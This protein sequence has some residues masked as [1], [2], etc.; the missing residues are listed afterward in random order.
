MK[1]CNGCEIDHPSQ[2]QHFCLIKDRE[3][4]WIYYHDEVSEK[5]DPGMVMKTAK[6]VC[7]ALGFTLSLATDGKLASPSCLSY[8]LIHYVQ[9]TVIYFCL[10]P[11]VK[12][13]LKNN[14]NMVGFSQAETQKIHRSLVISFDLSKSDITKYWDAGDS[15]YLRERE[16]VNEF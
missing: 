13:T 15:T 6:S 3:G 10:K 12:Q 11:P 9:T 16:R 1:R 7:S 5:V 14:K 2:R 8:V 4:A